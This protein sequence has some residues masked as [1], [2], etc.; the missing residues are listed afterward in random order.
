MQTKFEKVVDSLNKSNYCIYEPSRKEVIG[1][2]EISIRAARI[3]AGMSQRQL[4]EKLGVTPTTVSAWER[5]K[6]EMRPAYFYAISQLTGI[7][8]DHLVCPE[9]LK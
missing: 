6:K 7:S 8:V 9:S 5:G 3:N 2:G 4:A 1:M